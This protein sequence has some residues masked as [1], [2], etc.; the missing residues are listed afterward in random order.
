[1][2]NV[3]AT[4][5]TDWTVIKPIIISLLNHEGQPMPLIVVRKLLMTAH[6]AFIVGHADIPD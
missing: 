1:M 6:S 3:V 2:R 4:R 5:L